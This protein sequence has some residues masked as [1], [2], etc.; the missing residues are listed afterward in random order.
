M[1]LLPCPIVPRVEEDDT[2]VSLE[3]PRLNRLS[4]ARLNQAP[5]VDPASELAVASM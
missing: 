4:V 5:F 3:S 2:A 1:D